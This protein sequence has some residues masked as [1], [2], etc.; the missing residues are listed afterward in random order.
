MLS[1]TELSSIKAVSDEET[2][3]TYSSQTTYSLKRSPRD[4]TILSW[5]G[6]H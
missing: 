1:P 4:K 3:D 2:E 5:N 6:I